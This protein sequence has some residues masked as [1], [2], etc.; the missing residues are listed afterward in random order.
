[1]HGLSAP[2]GLPRL[3]LALL[4]LLVTSCK[5]GEPRVDGADSRPDHRLS[6]G[7]ASDRPAL[8][9]TPDFLPADAIHVD[10][11]GDGKTGSGTA[12]DP[13][14]D[15]QQALDSAPD[16]A[17]LLIHAGSYAAS[18][19]AYSDPGCGN[20][21]DADFAQG[22]SATRGF[23]VGG[24]ALHL[25]GEGPDKTVLVTGAG[26]GVLFEDAGSS[27]I[28]RLK[29]TGGKRDADG[30]ATDAGVVVRRTKLLAQQVSVSGN[31][32]LYTGP[33]PDPIVGVGGIFGREQA[34]LTILDSV[35]E[36]NSWDGIALYR[37]V[38]GKPG[39]GPTA[40][41]QGCRIGCTSGCVNPRGRGVGIGITWDAKLTAL[42]NV[43]HHYWKGIG[44]FGTSVVEAR[45]NVVRD[46]HGWG[47]VAS[48]SSTMH[49][50]N[51]VVLRSGTTG[52]AAWSSGVQG[53]FVNNI[54]VGNGIAADEWVGKKTGVWFN[55][56][57]LS[58]KLAYNLIYDNKEHDVCTG[59]T[60]GGV[61]C[62]ALPFEGV[63]GNLSLDPKLVGGDDVHLQPGSPATD[64]GDPAIK[65][66]DGS[67]SDLGAYGGPDAPSTLP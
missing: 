59:G 1:M 19:V 33:L 54:V 43:V 58:F 24:K 5:S 32:D 22:A 49:A 21:S 31:D 67:S 46:Q 50:V 28:G 42:G 53:S 25:W 2:P 38:P 61:A 15:L 30:K 10:D 20:C 18:P 55:A 60:P 14:R 11:L 8:D 34:E 27:S 45:N 52:M 44:S 3:G 51:N 62:T 36:D 41:V 16:G 12:A 23:L 26:Y 64:A 7:P 13:Y 9:L 66:Q 48:G 37:G 40:L 6:D 29:V 39:S 17:T 47:I 56:S 65:D 63:N 57:A 35:I 4:L